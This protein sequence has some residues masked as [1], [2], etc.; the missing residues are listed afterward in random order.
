MEPSNEDYEKIGLL[1]TKVESEYKPSTPEEK[2]F[3]IDATYLRYLRARGMDIDK[4][5]AML[6]G[7]LKWRAKVHPETVVCKSCLSNHRSHSM[8]VIG[9]DIYSRP[10]F[11]SHFTGIENR[12][13]DDNIEHLMWMLESVFTSDINSAQQ[14]VW[15]VDYTGFSVSDMNPSTGKKSLALFSDQYPERLGK[16]ILLDSPYVFSGLW[17]I[18]SPIIDS[19]THAKVE[20]V[21]LKNRSSA[22]KIFD[23]NLVE[24]LDRE[25]Q[26]ARN[27]KI[28]K[29]K[30][31][32]VDVSEPCPSRNYRA[33]LKIESTLSQ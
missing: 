17:K 10:V 19:R 21:S 18:L 23:A 15:V 27:P 7:T 20:F 31:W 25:I 28:L 5:Y 9:R 29:D 32:W 24:R 13:P 8:R 11:Y 14:Y 2:E 33:E 12:E 1:K 3:L 16:A 22:F 30:N 4:A 6:I 26:E